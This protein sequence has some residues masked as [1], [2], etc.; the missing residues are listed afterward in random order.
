MCIESA[1]SFFSVVTTLHTSTNAS[2]ASAG[3]NCSAGA[4]GAA[5]EH[6]QAE[7]R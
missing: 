1:C 3:S 6:E 7:L 4:A 2:V 5:G